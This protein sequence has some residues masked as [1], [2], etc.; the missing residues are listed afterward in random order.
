MFAM[1]NNR[2]DF[3][4]AWI[5]VGIL[6]LMIWGWCTSNPELAHTL[7]ANIKAFLP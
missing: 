6:A 7:W 4:A 5:G 1:D 3:T 2:A